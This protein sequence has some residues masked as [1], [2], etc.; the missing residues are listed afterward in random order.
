M[1][2]YH[3]KKIDGD[4]IEKFH[5]ILT[6]C[7]QFMSEKLGLKHWHP[8]MDLNTF[9]LLMQN[10][11][12][13]GIYQNDIAIA[14]FNLSFVSRDYYYDALWSKHNVKA[15]YLGQL[16]INPTLQGK[17][18]G[19]WCMQQIEE[20]SKSSDVKSIRFD[21]L[22]A[23]PWLKNFYL[24]LGYQTRGL[25]NPKGWDLMCFEKNL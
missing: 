15:I 2:E 1:N 24:K 5:Q 14:T 23:H 4:E 11:D 9:Q 8:F 19:K 7:G 20:I 3:L 21:A 25:V 6:S 17:G 16:A 10:K 22:N 18:L 13:Y 12:L